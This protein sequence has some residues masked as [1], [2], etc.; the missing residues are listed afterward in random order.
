VDTP[1]ALFRPPINLPRGGHHYRDKVV[2]R[3]KEVELCVEGPE[4]TSHTTAVDDRAAQ[5]CEDCTQTSSGAS[6]VS[7][8]VD[9][10]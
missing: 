1:N 2:K 3:D 6:T 7:I 9:V 10:N 4:V 5:Q 8:T